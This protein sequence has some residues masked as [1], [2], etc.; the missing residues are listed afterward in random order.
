MCRYS[1][2]GR[3]IGRR[4]MATSGAIPKW[5]NVVRAISSEGW[6]RIEYHTTIRRL[7][8]SDRDVVAYLHGET[9]RLPAFYADRLRNDLGDMYQFLP[10]G[11][12]AHAPLAY[13]RTVEEEMPLTQLSVGAAAAT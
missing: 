1:F 2:S 6:G 10:P 4:F 13:L 11:G 3:A 7:L 9:D 8:D 12:D 5:M